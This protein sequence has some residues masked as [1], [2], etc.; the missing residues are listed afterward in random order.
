MCPDDAFNKCQSDY[1]RPF[2]EPVSEKIILS[3]RTSILLISVNKKR[4]LEGNDCSIFAVYLVSPKDELQPLM[5]VSACCLEDV[6]YFGRS[7][8]PLSLV[9]A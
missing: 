1:A 2:K 7:S 6:P 4:R 3:P 9:M 5:K 8:C